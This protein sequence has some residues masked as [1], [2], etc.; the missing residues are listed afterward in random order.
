MITYISSN[1]NITN[2]QVDELMQVLKWK[3]L[4]YWVYKSYI[5]LVSL[6]LFYGAFTANRRFRSKRFLVPN[7]CRLLKSF[8]HH[9]DYFS[10]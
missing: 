2:K 3:D 6:D 7:K 4:D 8:S 10:Q 5:S 1:Y 9:T